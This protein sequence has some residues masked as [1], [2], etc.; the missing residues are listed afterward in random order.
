[1][2]D[3]A[4]EKTKRYLCHL[5][6]NV[7]IP[8]GSLRYQAI[9]VAAVLHMSD[10]ITPADKLTFV[11]MPDQSEEDFAELVTLYKA[12]QSL[13]MT[14]LYY[15]S[16]AGD[17]LPP[18]SQRWRISTATVETFNNGN[19]APQDVFFIRRPGQRLQHFEACVADVK[20]DFK[21]RVEAQQRGR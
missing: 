12:A 16:R 4:V 3:P 18:V 8:D 9:D 7:E 14:P 2:P 5:P 19:R 13:R 11:K 10:Y 15:L 1:M 21:A 17:Q 6:A 20:A